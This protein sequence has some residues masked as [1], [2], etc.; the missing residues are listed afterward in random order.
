MHCLLYSKLNDASI[1]QTTIALTFSMS[2]NGI[3]GYKFTLGIPFSG[4]INGFSVSWIGI[5]VQKSIYNIYGFY[6][7]TIKGGGLCDE[8]FTIINNMNATI[9]YLK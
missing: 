5:V 2:T 7:Q 4:Y 6:A 8:G 3:T 1:K 9:F